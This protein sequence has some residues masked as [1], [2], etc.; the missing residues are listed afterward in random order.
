MESGKSVGRKVAQPAEIPD[1]KINFIKLPHHSIEILGPNPLSVKIFP[2][3]T[4]FLRQL[5]PN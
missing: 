5:S 3:K 4:C 1:H 2:A